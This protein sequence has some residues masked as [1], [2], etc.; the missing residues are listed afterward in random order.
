MAATPNWIEIVVGR[1]A[2]FVII[3]PAILVGLAGCNNEPLIPFS[4]DTPPLILVPAAE[5]G[6]EDGRGRFREIYCQIRDDHGK[7]LPDDRSCPDA[8]QRRSMSHTTS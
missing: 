2:R 3:A 6:I 8:L 1:S 4:K 7:K 5:A